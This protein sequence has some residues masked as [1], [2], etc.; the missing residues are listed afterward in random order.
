MIVLNYNLRVRLS[1]YKT[2]HLILLKFC[3][4]YDFKEIAFPLKNSD[5]QIN[6]ILTPNKGKII[7]KTNMAI[8][9][10]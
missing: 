4:N 7:P 6:T 3:E 1:I 2:L 10:P 9:K 8:T 5:K